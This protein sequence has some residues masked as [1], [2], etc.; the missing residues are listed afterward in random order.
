MGKIKIVYGPKT[1][2]KKILESEG[3][4]SDKYEHF[5]QLVIESDVQRLVLEQPEQSNWSE[6]P[7]KVATIRQIQNLV[8]ESEEYSSANKH[9]LANYQIILGKYDIGNMFVHNPPDTFKE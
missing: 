8:I 3:L 7:K 6:L 1:F 5:S 4:T 9:V 2:F